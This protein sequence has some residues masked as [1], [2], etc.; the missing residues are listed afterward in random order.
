MKHTWGKY[1]SRKGT[2]KKYFEKY[3][4]IIE[5]VI[6]GSTDFLRICNS[7]L[8][9]SNFSTVIL[10]KIF[11][12]EIFF[13]ICKIF[14]D[15]PFS[16]SVGKNDKTVKEYMKQVWKIKRDGGRNAENSFFR[17]QRRL[18]EIFFALATPHRFMSNSSENKTPSF[19][20]NPWFK[21]LWWF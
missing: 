8:D 16:A 6:C 10:K 14:L 21:R 4:R 9:L 11:R 2:I 5:K 15:C 1:G 13:G 7:F 3:F 18:L 12:F 17:F 20:H 19:Y